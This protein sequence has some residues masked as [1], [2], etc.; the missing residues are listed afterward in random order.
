MAALTRAAL[1]RAEGM[2]AVADTIVGA[3]L[4]EA[5]R[6]GSPL[7]VALVREQLLG[8]D[9]EGYAGACEALAAA[10]EAD[11]TAITAPV[12]LL[13]GDADRVSP[14]GV[15]DEMFGIFPN[16]QLHILE[17]VGHWHSLEAPGA[18]THRLLD[19]LLKP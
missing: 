12:L 18:V 9:P 5:T 11:L 6:A 8:Q 7:A 4:S 16:A 3:A 15:N 14:V 19:F 10:T 13:T 2:A 1:V 17:D